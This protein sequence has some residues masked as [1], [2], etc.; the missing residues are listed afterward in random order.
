MVFYHV[1]AINNWREILLDQCTKLIY[2][3]LYETATAISAGISGPTQEV[4][5]YMQVL[6][7]TRSQSGNRIIDW[8]RP[9]TL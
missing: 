9:G 4:L 2:S 6:L 8:L 5:S 3:G 7:I 1:H